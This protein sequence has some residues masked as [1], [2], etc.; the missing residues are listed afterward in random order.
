MTYTLYLLEITLK[1]PLIIGSKYSKG[2]YAIKDPSII[3]GRL[4]WGALLSEAARVNSGIAVSQHYKPTIAVSSAFPLE[5]NKRCL[6]LHPFSTICKEIGLGGEESCIIEE[7]NGVKRINS[8]KADDLCILSINPGKVF[9][10]YSKLHG[11]PCLKTRDGVSL[12]RGL[13]RNAA[14]VLV[15]KEGGVYEK[16]SGISTISVEMVAIS[17]KTR[18]GRHGLVYTYEAIRPGTKYYSLIVGEET[19]INQLLDTLK[20]IHGGHILLR[21]GRATSRG[22]GLVELRFNEAQKLLEEIDQAYENCSTMYALSPFFYDDIGSKILEYNNITIKKTYSAGTMIVRGWSRLY[23][24][25]TRIVRALKPGSL[26]VIN[27]GKPGKPYG[28][29]LMK[30]QE[31]S[32]PGFN[33]IVP[34]R[35]FDKI[36]G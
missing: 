27:N 1:E 28:E 5:N 16:C 26:I 15:K 33:F 22:Y 17:K 30:L 36:L 19:I 35:V 14:G 20:T 2:W 32:G 13:R 31:V 3:T 4:F 10:E 9:E 12:S 21:V 29:L 7:R 8:V 34:V 23:N 25:P 18:S 24:K 6:P 11:E